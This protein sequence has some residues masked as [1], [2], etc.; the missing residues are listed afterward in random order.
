MSVPS[1]WLGL[2]HPL[3]HKRVCPPPP[4]EPKCGGPPPLRVRVWGS[5]NSDDWRKSLAICLLCGVNSRYWL[6][7]YSRRIWVQNLCFIIL[8]SRAV[9]LRFK[10]AWTRFQHS[11]RISVRTRNYFVQFRI[12]ESDLWEW[13]ILI[14][15][16]HNLLPKS[17]RVLDKILRLRIRNSELRS[18]IREVY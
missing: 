3:S 10:L 7:L 17:L 1:P 16:E 5:P 13:W 6:I 9:L 8:R 15:P 11:V 12:W 18:R 4:P 2:P 14:L